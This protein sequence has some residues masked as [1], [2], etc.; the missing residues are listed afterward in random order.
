ML[1]VRLLVLC[2]A[3]CTVGEAAC[4]VCEAACAVCEAACAV[5][6]VYHLLSDMPTQWT[7]MTSHLGLKFEMSNV[8]NVEN[9]DMSTLIEL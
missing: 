3:A 9:G 4:A 6:D 1:C 7:S 5:C 8:S 2:E